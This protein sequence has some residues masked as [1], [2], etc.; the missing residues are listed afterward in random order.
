VWKTSLLVAWKTSLLVVWKSSLLVVWKSSLL[1][2]WRSSLKKILEM[3]RL[4]VAA[5]AVGLKR[6]FNL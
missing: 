2:V 6:K 1:V 4:L 3:R 5:A